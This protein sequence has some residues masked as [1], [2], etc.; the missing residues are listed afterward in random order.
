M[1]NSLFFLIAAAWAGDDFDIDVKVKGMVCSFCIQGVEKKLS[2]EKSVEK[3]NVDLNK[4]S[5]FI[6]LREAEKLS[7][8]QI[9]KLIL[10]AGYDVE[11]ITRSKSPPTSEKPPEQKN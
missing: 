4:S 11:K 3:F 2:S 5:V 10:D 9:K 7:D 6:W 8:E 1:F